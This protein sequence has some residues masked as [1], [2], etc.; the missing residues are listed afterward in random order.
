[1]MNKGAFNYHLKG[2]ARPVAIYYFV[3]FCLMVFVV[4]IPLMIHIAGEDSVQLQ[5]SVSGIDAASMIFLFVCGLA[6]FREDFRFLAQNGC[7]RKTVLKTWMMAA[8][9]VS[10]GMAVIN[11]FINLAAGALGSFN[12]ISVPSF[13]EYSFSRLAAEMNGVVLFLANMLYNFVWNLAAVCLGNLIASLYYR[14]NKGG[15]IA[16]SVG[17][18]VFLSFIYPWLDLRL[19][20]GAHEHTWCSFPR[21]VW[22]GMA[23]LP[24]APHLRSIF[25]LSLLAAHSARAA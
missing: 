3:I 7:S 16:V 1:M 9:I 23:V 24:V 22:W 15:R 25:H 13:F 4:G 20:W 18:P 8:L 11:D 2:Y 12:N 6:A 21:A 5:S 10:F 19:L 17:V 14:M